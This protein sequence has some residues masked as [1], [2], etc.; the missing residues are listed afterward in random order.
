LNQGYEAHPNSKHGFDASD[1]GHSHQTSRHIFRK[2]CLLRTLLVRVFLFLLLVLLLQQE[3]AIA[4][5]GFALS[6]AKCQ[7]KFLRN[8]GTTL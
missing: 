1:L 6:E 4:A 3:L 2:T 8:P 5:S 7:V